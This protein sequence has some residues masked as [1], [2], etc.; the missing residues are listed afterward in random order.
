VV[1]DFLP[2]QDFFVLDEVTDT[3]KAVADFEPVGRVLL[4]FLLV[5]FA[6]PDDAPVPVRNGAVP[7]LETTTW[8]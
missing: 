7:L 2:V 4:H 1:E 3:G 5:G 6:N 8:L